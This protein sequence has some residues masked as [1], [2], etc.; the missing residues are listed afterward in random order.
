MENYTKKL[1]EYE[2][3][4]VTLIKHQ[5]GQNRA[6]LYNQVLQ[7]WEHIPIG[8]KI[9]VISYKKFG[10]KSALAFFEKNGL[11]CE[12]V[13][14]GPGG[15]RLVECEKIEDSH[16]RRLDISETVEFDFLGKNYRADVGNSIFSKTGLDKGTRFLLK[17]FFSWGIDLNGK[18]VADMGAGWGAISMIIATEFPNARVTAYERDGASFEVAQKNLSRFPQVSIKQIDLTQSAKRKHGTFD[19]ILSNPPFHITVKEREGILGYAGSALKTKGEMI[20]VVEKSFVDRFTLT[21]ES[22]F[23]FLQQEQNANYCVLRYRKD[24]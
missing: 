4:K 10:I 22:F 21:A 14:K 2:K 24:H 19:Y 8:G 1:K 18:E 16:L 23:D 12:I 15:L 7:A 13:G 9:V 5:W 3:E 20:F 11:T 6:S 17:T